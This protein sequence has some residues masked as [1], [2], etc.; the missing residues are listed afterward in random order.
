MLRSSYYEYKT[1]GQS[2]AWNNVKEMWSN[3]YKL[4][5]EKTELCGQV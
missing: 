5:T 4:D 1:Q 2:E 3:K